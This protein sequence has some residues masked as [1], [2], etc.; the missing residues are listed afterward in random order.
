MLPVPG[1]WE[2]FPRIVHETNRTT[3]ECGGVKHGVTWAVGAIAEIAEDRDVGE[4]LGDHYA[5]FASVACPTSSLA[6]WM[7]DPVESMSSGA[8]GN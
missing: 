1:Y 7:H 4:I 8:I 6:S 5:H 3:K 2:I